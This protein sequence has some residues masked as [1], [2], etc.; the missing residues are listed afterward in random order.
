MSKEC[1]FKSSNRDVLDAWEAGLRK[2]SEYTQACNDLIAQYPGYSLVSSNLCGVEMIEAISRT[3]TDA[4]PPGPLWRKV[5]WYWVPYCKTKAGK[6]L[7]DH[8]GTLRSERPEYPGMHGRALI[9]WQ[10]ISP[11][12][13]RVKDELVVNWPISEDE[14]RSHSWFD[15]KIWDS[16]KMSEFY[17][18]KESVDESESSKIT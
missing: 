4:P 8:L 18:L 11:G 12:V 13:F 17:V 3:D 15:G 1:A 2:R 5:K 6:Q 9:G 7:H 14:V 16:L 10:S